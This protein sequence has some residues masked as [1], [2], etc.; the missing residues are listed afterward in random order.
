MPCICIPENCD[1]TLSFKD[2][3]YLT[4]AY[5]RIIVACSGVVALH[6][7]ATNFPSGLAASANTS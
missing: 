3:G 4:R 1:Q 5:Q 6:A 2:V 7:D